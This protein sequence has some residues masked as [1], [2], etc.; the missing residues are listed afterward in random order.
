MFLDFPLDELR[1]YCP[2][3][4]EPPDFDRFWKDT[5]EAVRGNPLDARYEKVETGLRL[6]DT[7]DVTYRGFGGQEVKAWLQVPHGLEP[8]LPCVVEYIGYGGGRGDPADWLFWGAAGFAH[9]IMDTRGQGSLWKRGDTPDGE[10]HAGDPQVPGFLTRGIRQ[11]ATYYYRRV[12]ADAVRAVEAARASPLVQPGQVAVTGGSQGGGI[13]LAVAGLVHDLIAVM[14]DVPFLCHYR[15]AAGLTDRDPYK[16]IARY[17]QFHRGHV[18]ETFRTLSYF[19]GVNFAARARTPALFSVGL[20]DDIC[21]PR[22]VFA[23]YNHY[24]GEKAIRVWEYNSHEGGETVHQ[25]VK[26]TFLRS[27]VEQASPLAMHAGSPKS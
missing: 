21:P 3:R 9:F 8:P 23:A 11:P 16:E 22:T 2:P 24:A 6:L 27:L 18:E 4:E 10:K 12:F 26:L 14:P 13:S 15:I 5:L 20:M 17:C 25:L 7:F 19:D 1:R